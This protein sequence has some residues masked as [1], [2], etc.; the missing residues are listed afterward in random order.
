MHPHM[1]IYR[2]I[3]CHVILSYT[4]IYV[5]SYY[6]IY[7]YIYMYIPYNQQFILTGQPIVTP[8]AAP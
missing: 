4:Y 1:Y 2:S 8:P 6:L 3:I 5:S 7:I